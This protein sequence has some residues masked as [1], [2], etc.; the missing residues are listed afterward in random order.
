MSTTVASTVSSSATK[1]KG[2]EEDEET[3]RAREE[4]EEEVRRKWM[5]D[6]SFYAGDVNKTRS[7]FPGD[8]PVRG[9]SLYFDRRAPPL[10]WR[11]AYS[12]GTMPPTPPQQLLASSRVLAGPRRGARGKHGHGAVPVAARGGLHHKERA[13]GSA[14]AERQ[15]VQDPRAH[16]K[17]GEPPTPRSVCSHF[18]PRLFGA[19]P[20]SRALLLARTVLLCAG[21]LARRQVASRIHDDLHAM[22]W[23]FTSLHASEE[24]SSPETRQQTKPRGQPQA[25]IPGP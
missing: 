3:Q 5:T 12:P 7:R 21:S 19:R 22:R 6:R 11:H 4:L 20:T 9:P 14:A 15:P 23:E 8:T 18:N 13:G 1:K 16:H 10:S 17:L 25:G 24:R 2:E